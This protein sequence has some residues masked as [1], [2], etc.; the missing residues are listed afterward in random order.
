MSKVVPPIIVKARAKFKR[1]VDF[2]LAMGISPTTASSLSTGNYKASDAMLSRAHDIVN[3]SGQKEMAGS[4]IV[5]ANASSFEVLYD[6][7]Q[8]MGGVWRMKRKLGKFWIGVV[9]LPTG[10]ALTSFK[11]IGA[12]YAKD[13][14]PI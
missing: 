11:L 5:L 4:L 1:T 7:G 12:P 8:A 13:I 14:I 9:N 10:Q 2:A 6:A 3:G